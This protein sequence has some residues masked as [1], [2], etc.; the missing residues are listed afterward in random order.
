MAEEMARQRAV[1]KVFVINLFVKS[2][3]NELYFIAQSLLIK[4]ENASLLYLCMPL[5]C[6]IPLYPR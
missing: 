1:M 5:K 4:A 2:P 3:K 6:G